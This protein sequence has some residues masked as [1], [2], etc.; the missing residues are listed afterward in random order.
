MRSA[1]ALLTLILLPPLA[2][3]PTRFARIEALVTEAIADHQLPGAVIVIGRGD[4]VLYK[5]AFGNRAV[6]PDIGA[7]AVPLHVREAPKFLHLVQRN[8][9]GGPLAICLLGCSLGGDPRADVDRDAPDL[10]VHQLALAGV[11]AGPHL[12]AELARDP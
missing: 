11:E 7:L 1:L 4:A 5:R 2:A 3:E 8:T 12:D 9:G 6:S 10:P